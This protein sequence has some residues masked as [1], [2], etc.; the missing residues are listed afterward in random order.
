LSFTDEALS[1]LPL[2]SKESAS[3]NEAGG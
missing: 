1:P 2:T 3:F